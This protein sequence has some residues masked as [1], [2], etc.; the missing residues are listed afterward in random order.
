M[1]VEPK[2]SSQETCNPGD[3]RDK[4]EMMTQAL[5]EFS[6]ARKESG[7]VTGVGLG[8]GDRSLEEVS[9]KKGG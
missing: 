2:S 9:P 5:E 3:T 1:V 6:G 4:S 7:P 8:L